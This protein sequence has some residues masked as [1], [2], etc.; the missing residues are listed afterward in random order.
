MALRDPLDFDTTRK[1]VFDGVESAFAERYPIENDQYKLE[2]SNVG[3]SGKDKFSLKDQ[4]KAIL[5]RSELARS[6][7]GT[8]SLIDRKTNK[9][10]DSKKITLAKVP[11]MT[12]RGTFILGGSEYTVAQQMRLRPG[13]Y[14]RVKDN[15]E[16]EAHFNVVKG[17]PSFRV[18]MDSDSGV[19]KM[20]IGQAKLPL[21]PIL[22]AAGV[23]EADIRKQW[24]AD[25]LAANIA[26]SKGN[27][28]VN[29]AWE[30]LAQARAK[31]DVGQPVAKD[32]RA[33]FE[34]MELD[35]QVTQHTL[36]Q[37]YGRA[38]P[39]TILRATQKLIN[40][41]KGEEDTDDRDSLMYQTTWSVDDLLKE[42][43]RA[44]ERR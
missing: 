1:Y 43:S 26:K 14:T 2:L 36:G 6:I 10:I 23:S 5:S 7:R 12:Q 4:K 28:I 34:A 18:F 22:Q 8:V 42:R 11:Y 27:N 39:D 38:T 16:L 15:G 35:P 19:F 13:V 3:Y 20:Q 40:I 24:G 30:R 37:P 21:Y 25:L 29:K 44:S 41:N 31:K 9:P 33:V 32:F 17:G